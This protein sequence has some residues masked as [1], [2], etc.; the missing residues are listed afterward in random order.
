MKYKILLICIY[1]YIYMYVCVC[2]CCAFVCLDNKIVNIY[3]LCLVLQCSYL[4]NVT[5]NNIRRSM[6]V[7]G[8]N[9]RTNLC[10]VTTVH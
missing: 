7:H 10:D 5:I 8:T 4:L 6:S 1:K 2:V 9:E 3:F